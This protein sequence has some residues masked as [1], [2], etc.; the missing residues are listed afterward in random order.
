MAILLSVQIDSMLPAIKNPLIRVA[1]KYGLMGGMLV[2]ALIVFLYLTNKNPLNSARYSDLFVLLLFILFGIIEYRNVYND[3]MLHFW[4]GLSIGS[5]TTL[6]IA[7]ISS[8]SILI[9]CMIDPELLPGYITEKL[10]FIQQNKET[11]IENIDE[12]AYVDTVRGVREYHYNG[13]GIG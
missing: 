12:R 9:I 10:A 11:V 1:I 5:I 3:K 13:H 2:V 8:V 7:F 6:T 4:Q